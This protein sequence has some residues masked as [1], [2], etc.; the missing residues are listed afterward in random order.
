[1]YKHHRYPHQAGIKYQIIISDHLEVNWC[2]GHYHLLPSFTSNTSQQAT[3]KAWKFLW[4]IKLFTTG[5]F[6]MLFCCLLI[7]Q[8]QIFRKFF[9]EY[10]LS[11]KQIGP[12]QARR[13]ARPDW[14]QTVC[15]SHKQMTLGDKELR[16]DGV[17]CSSSHY[18]NI[19][20]QKWSSR[21]Q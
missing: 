18:N 5:K 4:M 11:V 7:F 14:V 20:S 21:D 2:Q 9:Q 17:C 15:K 1:M 19:T 12:S 13:F 10:H 6:F 8:N 3:T 16:G